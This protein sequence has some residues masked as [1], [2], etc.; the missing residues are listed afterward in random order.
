[1]QNIFIGLLENVEMKAESLQKLKDLE[2]NIYRYDSTPAVK[3][4]VII[5]GN[6]ILQLINNDLTY[7]KYIKS[8]QSLFEIIR[9][10]TF[11]DHIDYLE[12]STE[13]KVILA[14]L[15]EEIEENTL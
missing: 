1:M 11:V 4:V 6:K 9:T 14:D 10:A 8:I 13:I 2:R 5:T 12:W 15:I 3:D 7:T